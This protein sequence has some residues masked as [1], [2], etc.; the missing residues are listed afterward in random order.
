MEDQL[1]SQTEGVGKVLW[2]LKALSVVLCLVL[3][4]K[5]DVTFR[6]PTSNRG[7]LGGGGGEAL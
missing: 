3:F 4:D 2:S 5:S 6:I 7:P 1:E